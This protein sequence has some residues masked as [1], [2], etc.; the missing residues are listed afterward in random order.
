MSIPEY[1]ESRQGQTW[2]L[3]DTARIVCHIQQIEADYARI[4]ALRLEEHAGR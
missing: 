3:E 4:L 1:L 2:T